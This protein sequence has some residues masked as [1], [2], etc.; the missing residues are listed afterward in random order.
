MKKYNYII[1]LLI[2]IVLWSCSEQEKT[3]LSDNVTAPTLA[4]PSTTTLVFAAANADNDLAAF[5]W[6]A[7]NYGY[8]APV[9]YSLV[10]DKKGSN[11]A[12]AVEVTSGVTTSATVK[13]SALNAALLVLGAN[14]GEATD[15]E[16]K[17]I[18][19]IKNTTI[20]NHAS[21]VIGMNI[22]P[23]EVKIN[24][25]KLY[26]PGDLNGWTFKD[27][28]MSVKS[29]KLYEGYFY[30]PANGAFK[31]TKVAAW[32]E[33]QTIGDPNAS[34]TSGTLQVGS[35]GG[36]NIAVTGAPGVFKINV[37]LTNESSAT[38][39]ILK[40]VWAVVGD[41]T[42]SWDVDQAMTYDVATKVWTK[43][44]NLSAGKIKFRANGS[45]DVSYGDTGADG[46]LDAGGDDIVVSA[47]GN[48]TIT[49][50]LSNPV[51][52]YKLKKN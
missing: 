14:P 46:K 41:A 20:D 8:Q 36:N 29:N 2:G 38:Y 27:S 44:M 39:T 1:A 23:Y 42:G 25:P 6:T 32:D 10:V 24:Y 16:M 33:A 50:D 26:V 11:F 43:T 48:Y 30:F 47:A 52:K 49:L 37:N 13:V 5:T 21:N 34:G 35:W 3:I 51:Y 19:S 45:W 15:V 7:A 18:S 22:T 17:V 28:I 31:L 9:S 4:T 12:N 40:T